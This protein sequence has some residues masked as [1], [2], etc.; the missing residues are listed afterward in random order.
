MLENARQK[1]F[2]YKNELET[3][4]LVNEFINQVIVYENEIQYH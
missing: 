1:I 3:K 4:N 2:V